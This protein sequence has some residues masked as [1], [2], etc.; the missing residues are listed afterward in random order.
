MNDKAKPQREN[1]GAG[2]R[3]V[4]VLLLALLGTAGV[5]GAFLLLVQPPPDLPSDPTLLDQERVEQASAA[6]NAT[7]Y[8]LAK[9]T[10]LQIASGSPFYERSRLI[11]G[12]AAMRSGSNAD[13]MTHYLEIAD[14]TS[15]DALVAAFSLAEL[16]RSEGR[17]EEAIARYLHVYRN[18]PNP[19]M[20]TN[21]AVPQSNPINQARVD[22]PYRDTSNTSA[23]TS[24]KSA[25]T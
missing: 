23:C 11:A 10:A 19:T 3:W 18:D 9:T 14:R 22:V 6:L 13:A 25:S 20:A 1:A 5:I 2:N 24:S 4:Q 16:Y 12:E 15:S 17:I 21:A 8:E 7:R